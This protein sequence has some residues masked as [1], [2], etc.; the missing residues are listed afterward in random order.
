MGRDRPQKFKPVAAAGSPKGPCLDHAFVAQS[1]ESER[2]DVAGDSEVTL[3][4][5]EAMHA[6]E[7][8]PQDQQR[9]AFADDLQR[10]GDG[11]D[12][13]EAAVGHGRGEGSEGLRK[14]TE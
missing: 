13:T 6:A 4:L 2:E 12:L 14:E 1:P 8:V 11:A 10:A 5:V 3:D 7:E 9:P